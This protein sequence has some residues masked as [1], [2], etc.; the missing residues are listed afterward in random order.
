L[1]ACCE[2]LDFI[3]RE[4]LERRFRDRELMQAVIGQAGLE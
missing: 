2:P 3:E 1:H 4:R